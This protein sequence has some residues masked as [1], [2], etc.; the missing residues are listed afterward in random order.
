MGL[1]L[2]GSTDARVAATPTALKLDGSTLDHSLDS[3]GR[4]VTAHW[5]DAKLFNR[6]RIRGASMR[7][8]PLTG[9]GVANGGY[10]DPMT[11]EAQ[12][13]DEV[14]LATEDMIAGGEIAERGL[15]LDLSVRGRVSYLYLYTNLITGKPGSFRST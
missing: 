11:I 12:V 13:R 14:R 2:P 5:V 7:S 15:E 9:N 8:A 6:L 10:I 1:D 3:A 4:F